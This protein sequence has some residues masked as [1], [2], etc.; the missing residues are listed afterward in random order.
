MSRQVLVGLAIFAA[1]VSGLACGDD[2]GTV[3]DGSTTNPDGGGSNDGGPDKPATTPDGATDGK[4]GPAAEGGSGDAGDGGGGDAPGDA[5]PLT[6]LE[7]RG[8]YLVEHVIACPDCHTPR[9]PTGALDMSKYMAGTTECFAKIDTDCIYPRNLTPHATG[10]G[11][12]SNAEIKDMISKGLR[13]MSA[14]DRALHPIMPYYVF[15]NTDEEDLDAI[16]AFLKTLTPVEQEIPMKGMKWVIPEPVPAINLDAVPPVLE[17]Y[18]SQ[19]AAARGKYLATQIGLCIEC[20]TKHLM[21]AET[22]L[23]ETKFFQGGEEYPLMFGAIMATARSKNLTPDN[24]TGLG[25]WTLEDIVKSL[26]EGK[27]KMDKGICPPMPAGPMAAYGGLDP[28]DAR[29]IAHYLKSIA[30]AANMV[31]D[32]CSFPPGT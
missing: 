14:P 8:K 18:P 31:M 9:L 2:E 11:N 16:V 29:D 27:D 1:T 28:Q 22:A 3:A 26:I 5:A 4:D 32:M 10:L 17:T 12:R 7:Q 13:P 19:A 25:M 23:D 21:M 24:T 6:A 30:P 20:H 15:G